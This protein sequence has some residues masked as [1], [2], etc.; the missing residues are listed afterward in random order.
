MGRCSLCRYTLCAVRSPRNLDYLDWLS[1]TES[2]TDWPLICHCLGDHSARFEFPNRRPYST[3]CYVCMP[4]FLAVQE[5]QRYSYYYLFYRELKY[6]FECISPFFLFHSSSSS[7]SKN[8]VVSF[9]K[10][11]PLTAASR[12]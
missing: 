9:V 10:E 7:S 4:I 8:V 2:P 12:W 11:N 1:E 3:R 6:E 5:V